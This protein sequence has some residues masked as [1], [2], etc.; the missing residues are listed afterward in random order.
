MAKHDFGITEFKPGDELTSER[1]NAVI[2][3]AVRE[4][5]GGLSFSDG[6]GTVFRSERSAAFNVAAFQIDG[7]YT[8]ATVLDCTLGVWNP[9]THNY[10]YTGAAA[11]CID[12]RANVPD[13]DDNATGVG[14]WEL[15]DDYGRII[16][17]VDLDCPA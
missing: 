5:T 6:L 3:A 16:V 11:K 14:Y 15:S 2:R 1:L 10:G 17:V 13:P 7:A 9:A 8:N 12:R 4:V